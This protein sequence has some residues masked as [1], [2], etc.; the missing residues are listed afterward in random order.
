M[1]V[2]VSSIELS[3]HI[4]P[5]K[6]DNLVLQQIQEQYG[7]LHMFELALLGMVERTGEDGK[8]EL[9]KLPEVSVEPVN[10]ALPKMILEG[11]AITNSEEK[12]TEEELIRAI[13]KPP[14]VMS[15][16]MHQELGKALKVKEPKKAKP[17]RKSPN[18]KTLSTLIG[19]ICSACRSWA[20]LSK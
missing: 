13:D 8:Q 5:M 6:M 14:V 1:K 17:S 16:L 19:C 7:T 3:G 15:L 20:S 2:E 18:R 11:L 4:F 12:Y 10:F 9:I